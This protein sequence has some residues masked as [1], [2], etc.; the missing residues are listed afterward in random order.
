MGNDLGFV[1][2]PSA[3]RE[4]SAIIR[5]AVNAT[6]A[7]RR[8]VRYESWEYSDIA[9]RPI[10]NPILSGIDT[11]AVLVADITRLNFNV[12]Y[13]VGYAIGLKRRVLLIKNSTIT[14][15]DTLVMRTGI[16][17]TLG[18]ERYRNGDELVRIL[19][20]PVDFAPLKTQADVD[21]KA[22]VYL[23][24]TPVRTPEMVR[25]VARVKKARLFYR[26]FTPSEDVR[27][28]AI[29]AIRHVSRSHGVLVPLLS[30]EF[31]G[32]GIHNIRAAFVAGLAHGM[33]KRTLILQ[34]G[35]HPVP[36]DLRD[37]AQTYTSLDDINRH[38]E[39]FAGDIYEE[40]Q[41]S[42]VL[43]GA[44]GSVLQQI[45]LGDPMAE[46]EFQTLSNYYVQ[47]VEFNRTLRGEVN[48]VVGRKGTGK[49]A[50]F[51]Q[52]RDRIRS[53]RQN[54]VIDLKPE[55]YQLL[56]L[57]E[58]VLDYLSDGAKAH[59]ITAFW[60]YLLLLEICRKIIENDRKRHMYDHS[61]FASYQT[62]VQL[63]ENERNGAEGDFSERLLVLSDKIIE[64]YQSKYGSTR[65]MRLTADE[66]TE[67]L[68][69]TTLGDLIDALTDYLAHKDQVLV[70]FDN[71]DKGWSYRGIESGD[72]VILRCLIDASRWIQRE[73]RKAGL[74]ISCIVFV[75]N[76]IYQLL[77]QGSSD[78]GK[79]TRA[80]LDWSDPDLLREVLRRRLRAQFSKDFTF[81]QLWGKICTSHYEGEE[82]SQYLIDRCLMRPRNL[83]K[84][85][86]YCRG[87]AVNLDHERIES[88]DI[89][90]GLRSYSNDLVIEADRELAD[91]EPSAEGLIYQF[92]GEPSEMSEEEL[93]AVFKN[94]GVAPE[95]HDRVLEFLLY[96]GFLGI[97]PGTEDVR[98]VYTVGYDMGILKAVLRKN[99]NSV[100]FVLNPAFW[101]A[102]DV[103]T[104]AAAL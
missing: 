41:K 58:Q 72:I 23:L 102:L 61:L 96:F 4:L 104:T 2:Y 8:T 82:T 74:Q 93:G 7:R 35:R 53:N 9:G 34:D 10:T 24:E 87:F 46:N 19:E 78:F 44:T 20:K 66:V 43:E 6:N 99:R 81:E 29:D 86:E 56:K 54:V 38:I 98:Y 30:P 97:R 67:L 31:E 85:V 17:D 32:A 76:D 94:H 75:R 59:L 91:V 12:S 27:L 101:P 49:T 50:L 89:R 22:P 5:A 90:K 42:T 48:L 14:S 64:L 92:V 16:F 18:H 26:S 11:A 13:E 28:S 55:G 71:L 45:S 36:I 77:M 25:I 33:S 88:A 103:T 15:D 3:P 95:S 70:L 40:M 39:A 37:A 60:E 83:L 57:K 69:A 63:N 51:F 21:T 65:E 47:T 52:V 84:L 1:A 79:E 100:R 68:H 62:L 80:S 73:M